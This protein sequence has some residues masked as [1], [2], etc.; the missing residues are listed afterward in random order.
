MEYSILEVLMRR[1]EMDRDDALSWI[2]DAKQMVREGA[3]P[4]EVCR[5]EFGLEPDY[6]WDLLELC[7]WRSA[8][9]FSLFVALEEGWWWR[10]WVGP[11]LFKRG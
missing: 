10:G 8:D 4:E 9:R 7:C 2:E 11:P 5:Y 3:D 1:D 6:M